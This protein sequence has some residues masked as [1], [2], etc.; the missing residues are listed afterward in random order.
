MSN[1]INFKNAI[2][3]NGGATYNLLT[4]EFN[5]NNGYMVSIKDH[6]QVTTFNTENL[7]YE[8]ARY[9]KSKAEILMSGFFDVY[10]LGAWIKDD[11]L[12]LDVSVK[13]D[14]ESEALRIGAENNQRAIH[15]C[16]NGVSIDL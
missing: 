2:I 1:L 7:Q 15:D 16:N 11:N 9:V 13:V 10:F 6:E 5:P 3:N 8:I 14:D 4:G 12:V